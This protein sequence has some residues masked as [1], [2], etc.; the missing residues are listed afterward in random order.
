M[1]MR[2]SSSNLDGSGQYYFY[3]LSPFVRKFYCDSEM[4]QSTAFISGSLNYENLW[5]S[6]RLSDGQGLLV[7]TAAPQQS[8]A[9]MASSTTT[10]SNNVYI[11]IPTKVQQVKT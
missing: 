7:S 6:G 2:Q 10:M 9:S 3:N 11:P 8:P 5:D 4:D 1:L